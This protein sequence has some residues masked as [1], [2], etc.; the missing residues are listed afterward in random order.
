MEADEP[1][2]DTQITSEL[3]LN[4][5]SNCED[6]GLSQEPLGEMVFFKDGDLV[7]TQQMSFEQ[8]VPV[9]TTL[10]GYDCG[11]I[12][13]SITVAQ[14]DRPEDATAFSD[15]VVSSADLLASVTL[16]P[17]SLDWAINATFSL[18]GWLQRYPVTTVMSN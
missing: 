6:L 11:A 9:A 13:Y 8:A 14:V 3:K 18:D 4:V 12:D 16:E 15:L 5:T 2:T 1:V 7:Q 17:E 10:Y